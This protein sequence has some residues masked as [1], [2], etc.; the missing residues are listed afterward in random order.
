MPLGAY[1][2]V[3][4]ANDVRDERLNIGV[5]V[6]HPSDGFQSRFLKSFRRVQAIAPDI[7]LRK[8]HN[9]VNSILERLDSDAE[10][11]RVLSELSSEFREGLQVSGIYPARLQSLDATAD[12]L[13]SLLVEQADA[14]TV[15]HVSFHLKLS[16][17]L[18]NSVYQLDPAGVFEELGSR[19]IDGVTV[20]MGFRTQV[21]QSEMVWRAMSLRTNGREDQIARAK[22]T[23]ID[24][25]RQRSLQEFR[26]TKQIV[27]VELP[28]KTDLAT[29]SEYREQIDSIGADIIEISEPSLLSARIAERLQAA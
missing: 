18:K 11:H 7:R 20:N 25:W 6:W 26:D 8:L 9:M 1:A 15:E 28:K 19:K 17:S 4:F 5:L 12:R 14:D 21:R 16:E 2:I 27:T 24:I 10:G 29:L 22:A 3:R 13:Y 23:V